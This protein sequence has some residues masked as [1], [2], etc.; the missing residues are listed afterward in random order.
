M[1]PLGVIL[2]QMRR[3]LRPLSLLAAIAFVAVGCASAPAAAYF[4]D[5]EARWVAAAEAHDT[6]TL[7]ELLDDSFV[8]STF[9]GETRTKQDVLGGPPAAGSYKSVRLEELTV[10]PYGRDTVIVTSVNVLE[11]PAKDI[12][13][14]RF[15][16][17]F[18]K[19]DG[20]WRAVAA[21]E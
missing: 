17:V 3:P 12:V 16:D 15:T 18:R 4:K 11:G 19:S 8:D 9:R 6:A 20:R 1:Q 21:Q 10:R 7:G 13:R 5:L 2:R 14:V